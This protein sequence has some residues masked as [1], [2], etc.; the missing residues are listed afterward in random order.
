MLFLSPMMGGGLNKLYSW[1]DTKRIPINS[2]CMAFDQLWTNKQP[3][4][5]IYY[6]Y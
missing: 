5:P 6:R 2:N 4:S 1:F 3:F